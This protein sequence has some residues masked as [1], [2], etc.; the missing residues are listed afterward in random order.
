MHICCHLAASLAPLCLKRLFVYLVLC[1]S[2]DSLHGS[3]SS[4]LDNLLDV[5]ILGLK[6][7]HVKHEVQTRIQVS[8]MQ[9]CCRQVCGQS[10]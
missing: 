10:G 2:Q 5:V 9:L 4:C 8:N 1:V 3:L 7:K 6:D